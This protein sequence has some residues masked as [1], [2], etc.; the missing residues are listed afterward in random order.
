MV[1]ASG[2][3]V[4][5][6]SDETIPGPGGGAFQPSI[7]RANLDGSNE[8]I[9]LQSSDAAPTLLAFDP[10]NDVI[11]ISCGALVP[12][13]G[14]RS[15]GLLVLLLLGVGAWAIKRSLA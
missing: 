15:A 6:R 10:V 9:V 8:A 4:Y 2:G 5:W 12:A 11:P 13:L 1:D 14:L 7:S 3:T